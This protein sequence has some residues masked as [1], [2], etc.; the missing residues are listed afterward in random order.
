MSRALIAL[1]EVY[2]QEDGAVKIPEALVPYV[3]KER[4]DPSAAAR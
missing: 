3:G 1:I 2:Q 4:V